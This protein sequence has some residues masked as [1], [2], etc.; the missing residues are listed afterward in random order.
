[1]TSSKTKYE[2]LEEEAAILKVFEEMKN[3][4]PKKVKKLAARLHDEVNSDVQKRLCRDI[5]RAD[6]PVK[7]MHSCIVKIRE[8]AILI[9]QF[10]EEGHHGMIFTGTNG[11]DIYPVTLNTRQNW[12]N[13][14]DKWD[15]EQEML[16]QHDAVNA[17]M[18]EY[19]KGHFRGKVVLFPAFGFSGEPRIIEMACGDTT[20]M[21]KYPGT[22]YY[23]RPEEVNLLV[24][25]YPEFNRLLKN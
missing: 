3:P 16:I 23:V 18:K 8:C 21:V 9:E 25:T 7:Y 4:N 6:E 5:Y 14:E 1:M 12:L 20:G 13:K 19:D 17:W 22:N 10:I 24:A 15:P 2:G 11:C